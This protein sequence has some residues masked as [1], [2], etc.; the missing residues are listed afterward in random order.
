MPYTIFT[1]LEQVRTGL[2]DVNDSSSGG[3]GGYSFFAV[4]PHIVYG[5]PKPNH[6]SVRQSPQQNPA[7]AFRK[8][9]YGQHVQPIVEYS[10]NMPHEKYTLGMSTG[11]HPGTDPHLYVNVMD[12]TASH[13]PGPEG[14][15]D[16]CF[17]RILSGTDVIDRMH[18]SSKGGVPVDAEW[19]E[20]EP[21]P[22]AV[23]SVKILTINSSN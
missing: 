23:K 17:G 16:A 11:H 2:Y 6:L 10:P 5:G 12:N 1:F 21:G 9:P 4:A 15:G 14:R 13:G 20:V 18:R 22:I 8:F 19:K 3:G 7:D